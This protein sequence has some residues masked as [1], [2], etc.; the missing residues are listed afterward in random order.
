MIDSPAAA[1]PYE[2]LGIASSA[3]HGELRRAYRRLLRKTHPDTGGSAA[4]FHAVQAAWERVGDPDARADYDR[5]ADSPVGNDATFAPPSAEARRS[6]SS[7]R[8]RSFGHPGKR[9]RK[10]Y[11][12]A[13]RDWFGD[14]PL[15]DPY[16]PAVVRSAPQGIRA[17]LAKAMAEEATAR[18]LSGLGI[19][20]SV[21]NDIAIGRSDG[22][23]DHVVL[24]PAGLFVLRSEDWG[25]GVRVVRGDVVGETV[26]VGEEPVGSLMQDARWFTRTMRLGLAACVIVVPDGALAVPLAAI[27][28]GRN[29]GAVLVRRSVLP[30]LLRH[31]ATGS[32]SAGVAS[33]ALIRA[34]LHERIHLA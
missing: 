8:A 12:D 33:A 18:V 5:G 25:S 14:A 13:M 3:D 30:Q 1:T 21:W 17:L 20:Y 15:G 19:A 10:R 9:A 29:A 24:G 32:G 22:A 7:L 26:D 11:V 6:A 16:D 28:H 2:V 34:R 31:G 23:I 4:R 27:E